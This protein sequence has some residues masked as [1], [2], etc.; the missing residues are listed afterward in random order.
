[1]HAHS[2]PSR[3]CAVQSLISTNFS[4]EEAGLLGMFFWCPQGMRNSP[5]YDILTTVWGRS[6]K[7]RGC[8]VL[9]T[10]RKPRV[11]IWTQELPGNDGAVESQV[12]QE[13]AVTTRWECSC[14]PNWMVHQRWSWRPSWEGGHGRTPSQDPSLEVG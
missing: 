10:L 8:W 13:M 9:P 6:R 3:S 7:G 12:A 2:Y 5:N 11:P 4:G 14:S 1:M